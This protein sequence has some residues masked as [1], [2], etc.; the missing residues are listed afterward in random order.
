MHKTSKFYYRNVGLII[1][2]QNG[3]ILDNTNGYKCLDIMPQ[4]EGRLTVL[5]PIDIW[6]EIHSIHID[7][8]MYSQVVNEIHDFRI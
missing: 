8:C 6:I 2:I 1:F 3:A 5:K 4:L 7:F